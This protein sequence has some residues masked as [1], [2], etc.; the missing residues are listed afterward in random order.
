[1]D[2]S[3]SGSLPPHSLTEKKCDPNYILA[4]QKCDPND[5]L[6]DQ[7]CDPNNISADQMYDL[8]DIAIIEIRNR[9]VQNVRSF[10]KKAC[11]ES[12]SL[13]KDDNCVNLK[14]SLVPIKWRN[15]FLG[16]PA[17]SELG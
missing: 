10:K 7:K 6:A 16:Y 2:W 12:K 17:G 11:E 8:N 1:M 15:T 13:N 5:I 4:D 14:S 9:F 3:R